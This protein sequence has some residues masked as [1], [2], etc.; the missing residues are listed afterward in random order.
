MGASVENNRRREG[1]LRGGKAGSV[2]G[3]AAA[4]DAF[5]RLGKCTNA[6]VLVRR[7]SAGFDGESPKPVTVGKID[8]V[9]ENGR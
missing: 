6:A 2:T 8:P 9:Y 1:K 3:V 7:C 5:A 4:F